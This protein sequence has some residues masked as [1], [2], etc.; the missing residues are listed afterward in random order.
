VLSFDSALRRVLLELTGTHGAAVLP[1]PNGFDGATLVHPLDTTD[2]TEL[3]AKGHK[4]SRG[5]GALEL[6]RAI[7][8]GVPERASGEVAYHVLDAMLAIDE[9]IATS[10]PVTVESTVD[11]PPALPEDWNPYETTL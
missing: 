9:S 10:T 6:A 1:D 2:L 4:A 7:R 11:I 3:S 5:T 8:A